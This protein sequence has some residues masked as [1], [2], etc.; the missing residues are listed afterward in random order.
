MILIEPNLVV[1]LSTPGMTSRSRIK[2]S[3]SRRRRHRRRRHCQS[4][5]WEMW[6]LSGLLL[7]LTLYLS[8]FILILMVSFHFPAEFNP[9][10]AFS[11]RYPFFVLVTLA[12]MFFEKLD[13][14]P[15]QRRSYF[16][17]SSIFN[18]PVSLSL[19][20]PFGHFCNLCIFYAF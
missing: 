9:P 7:N 14:Q 6:E 8:W 10:A 18:Q 17:R 13:A 11:I 2:S 20:K 19:G 4:I 16:Q 5:T 3:V 12:D 1:V 15:S